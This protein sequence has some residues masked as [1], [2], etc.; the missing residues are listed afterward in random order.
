M[1]NLTENGALGYSTS[2]SK[3]LDLFTLVTRGYDRDK[4]IQL[5][6]EAY[7]EDEYTTLQILYHL[8]D[9]RN[10]K[11]EKELTL[12]LLEYMAEHYTLI[13]RMNLEDIVSQYGCYKMFCELYARDYQKNGNNASLVPL[14]LLT[15]ELQNENVLASKWAPNEH[16]MYNHRKNGYQVT[17]LCRI[18][19][20]HR[21]DGRP[22][23]KAY[24][25]LLKPLRTKANIVEQLCCSNK[26]DEIEFSKVAS[27]AM[28]LLSKKAF[29]K[30]CGDR[31]GEWKN[32]VRQGIAEV[33][34]QGLQ[35][36]EIIKHLISSTDIDTSTLEL[37][38][39][40]MV[41]KAKTQGS[42]VDALAIVDV[43]GSMFTNDKVRPIDVSI[44]LGLFIAE[45]CDTNKFMTFSHNPEIVEVKGTTLQQKVK[46]ITRANWGMST[47]FV[48]ALSTLL[49]H[50]KLFKVPPERMTKYLF[51]LTD[52]EFDQATSQ[53]SSKTPHNVVKEAYESA[54]YA[55]PKIIY[56]NLASRSGTLPVSSLNENVALVSGF[57]QTLLKAFMEL[58]PKDAIDPMRM[59]RKILEP[60]KPHIVEEADE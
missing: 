18:L 43:S 30:H 40:T 59:M 3:C 60:Y 22:D 57:S 50:A 42:L 17:K 45:V 13:W 4:L 34:T 38:W 21:S 20:L 41:D 46:S 44:A 51:V 14:A 55:L 15:K 24:R 52:M 54:G 58:D 1:T 37:Q 16:S 28:M 8:R 23:Y 11:G 56:W 53:G 47:N 10:G 7:A 25:N 35:P 2:G 32:A 5:F 27:K 19:K 29:P 33:K 12:I 6:N 48:K 31:F 36:H 9:C 39:K 26:W 49:S